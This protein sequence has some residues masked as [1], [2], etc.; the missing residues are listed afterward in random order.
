MSPTAKE[1]VGSDLIPEETRFVISEGGARRINKDLGHRSVEAGG[2][3]EYGSSYQEDSGGPPLYTREG[4]G[5]IAVPHKIDAF[6][7]CHN[8]PE[9]YDPKDFK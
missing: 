9:W 1:L 8:L 5:C 4:G 6:E 3:L 2:I 7:S